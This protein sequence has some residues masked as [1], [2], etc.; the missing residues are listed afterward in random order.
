MLHGKE[1]KK[2]FPS[3]IIAPYMDKDPPMTLDYIFI[4]GKSLKPLTLVIDGDK[5]KE[6]DD[7]IYASDHLA[8]VGEF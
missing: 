2:T 7:T 5:A 8:L 4:K 6:G 3:G 1:W